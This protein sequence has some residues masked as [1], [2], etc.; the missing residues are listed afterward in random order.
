VV[1]LEWHSNYFSGSLFSFSPLHARMEGKHPS[2]AKGGVAGIYLPFY[3]S[4][5]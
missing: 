2:E 1:I 3:P 5:F 4:I